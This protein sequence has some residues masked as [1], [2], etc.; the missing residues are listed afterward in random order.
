MGGFMKI[1]IVSANLYY[2][3]LEWVANNNKIG[4][5]GAMFHHQVEMHLISQAI[6]TGPSLCTKLLNCLKQIYR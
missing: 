5:K 1:N 3:W 2:R 4:I 6:A